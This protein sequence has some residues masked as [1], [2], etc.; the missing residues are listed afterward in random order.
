MISSHLISSHRTVREHESSRLTA[1]LIKPQLL[2]N[3]WSRN[4][5]GEILSELTEFNSYEKTT[6]QQIQNKLPIIIFAKLI[7]KSC[8]GPNQLLGGG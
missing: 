4:A 6:G 3:I 1:Q 7:S 2:Q 8:E 5:K